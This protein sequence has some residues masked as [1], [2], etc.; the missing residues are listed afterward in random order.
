MKKFVAIFIAT[1]IFFAIGIVLNSV[2]TELV[3]AQELIKLPLHDDVGASFAFAT[4]AGSAGVIAKA[5]HDLI[6]KARL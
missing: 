2:I 3:Y 1:V 6:M 5:I 4:I